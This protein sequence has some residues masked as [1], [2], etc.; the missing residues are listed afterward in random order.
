MD[1]NEHADFVSDLHLPIEPNMFI[2]FSC[3]GKLPSIITTVSED[4]AAM[5]AGVLVNR[6]ENNLIFTPL[7]VYNQNNVTHSPT[8]VGISVYNQ[9]NE[10][11]FY[12]GGQTHDFPTEPG[13]PLTLVAQTETLDG[14]MARHININQTYADLIDEATRIALR[15]LYFVE[16]ANVISVP[17]PLERRDIKRAEKRGWRIPDTVR[18][19][20][21]KRYASKSE[22]TGNERVYSHQF[23]VRG[24]YRHV[25]KGSHVR[26]QVCKGKFTDQLPCSACNNT[27]INQQII[28]PCS[29]IDETTGELTCPH[30][31]RREWTPSFW[32]GPEDAPAI[33]KTYNV[34]AA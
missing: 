8:P 31:C 12:W 7:F 17:V 3:D 27:G 13:V 6:W 24:F 5:I 25:Q 4:N 11:Q 33:I 23:Q 32:K 9:A 21:P 20:R 22:P 2:D 29:R 18:I 28:K 15:C 16:A 34:R 1:A 14:E 26:C 19:D 30:G 10:K